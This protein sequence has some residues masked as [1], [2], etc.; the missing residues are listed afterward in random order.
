[1]VCSWL[2]VFLHKTRGTRKRLDGG[3]SSTQL[4]GLGR[5]LRHSS[6]LTFRDIRSIAKENFMHQSRR[7][8]QWTFI[9]L[10]LILVVPVWSQV[11]SWDKETSQ[12]FDH[13]VQITQNLTIAV[14]GE[15]CDCGLS[16]Q[17]DKK[18]GPCTVN[19]GTGSCHSGSG[20]CCVCA[21]PNT[22]AMCG[23]ETCDCGNALLITKVSAPCTATSSS[24]ACRVGSGS[25]C[26][27]AAD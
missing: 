22:T 1:M 9:W 13:G 14:C 18:F 16:S 8:L 25:C 15:S 11:S 26:V 27:C 20:E 10:L 12:R 2:F 24:G 19:S 23:E 6:Q 4:L 5:P 21:V 7:M 17:V 3:P